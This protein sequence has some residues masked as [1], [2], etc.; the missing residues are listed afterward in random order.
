[1]S[2]PMVSRWPVVLTLALGPQDA[3]DDSLLTEA[4]AERLF[5]VACDA[6]F[7]L[8]TTVDRSSIEVR[9]TSTRRGPGTVGDSVSISVGVVELFAD[10]F[11]MAARIRP[12]GTDAIAAD[13]SCS[14]S[15]GAE[16]PASMRD[17]FISLAHTA[18]HF[19]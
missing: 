1:M 4:A 7:D 8:C 3:D 9:T 17:E 2:S 16:V 19:H 15:P 12:V 10:A 5:A 14:L 11:T 13:V 18:A 6:F